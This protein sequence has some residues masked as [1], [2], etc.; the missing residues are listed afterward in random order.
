MLEENSNKLKI[1]WRPK[2]FDILS[3]SVFE[4]D[5][6]GGQGSDGEIG[7]RGWFSVTWGT[8]KVNGRRLLLFFHLFVNYSLKIGFSIANNFKK[9]RKCYK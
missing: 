9:K 6:V 5:G 3:D 8:G 7:K 4:S 2:H 1:S